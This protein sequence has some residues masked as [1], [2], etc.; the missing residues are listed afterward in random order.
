MPAIIKKN[1]TANL[2]AVWVVVLFVLV[3]LTIFA[4]LQKV[5]YTPKAAIILPTPTLAFSKPDLIVKNISRDTNYYRAYFCNI[6]RAGGRGTFAVKLSNTNTL[7]SYAL[8]T[9]N[10]FTVPSP[11]TCAWTRGAACYHLGSNCM[12][13]VGIQAFVDFQNSVSELNES[14]NKYSKTFSALPCL[15][16]IRSDYNRDGVI[17]NL[18][19]QTWLTWHPGAVICPTMTPTITP[20]TFCAQ[21]TLPLCPNGTIVK[22]SLPQTP[23]VCPPKYICVTRTPTPASCVQYVPGD[24]NQDGVIDGFD[25]A[26][27]LNQ[28]QGMLICATPTPPTP[29]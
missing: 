28:H 10:P 1:K 4:A 27:W 12:D 2:S 11:G 15:R 9:T 16:Y 24:Y 19:Y 13:A 7:K 14:N 25:Y 18:D 29:S 21:P 22:S 17:S 20:T 5:S 6:S 8:G 23:G 26:I 3:I